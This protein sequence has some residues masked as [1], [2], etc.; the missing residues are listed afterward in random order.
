MTV[1]VPPPERTGDASIGFADFVAA[2][3][4][5][6]RRYAHAL[7]GNA[8]DAD[9]LL[10]ATLVKVYLAWD[11]LSDRGEL[12]AYA[13]TVMSRTFISLWRSWGRHE[14]VS[15]RLPERATDDDSTLA[16]RDR[17]RRGLARLGRRQRAIVVL[18]YVE[19]QEL[20]AIARTLG[21]SVGTVKSQLS[22]ALARLRTTLD[23]EGDAS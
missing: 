14:V 10:Q 17:L 8:S 6:L 18:R 13:R 21:I 19:D 5:A 1:L 23:P 9:D 4:V 15:D 12:G 22:R 2:E 11:R 20:S 16:E 7:T 3:Q